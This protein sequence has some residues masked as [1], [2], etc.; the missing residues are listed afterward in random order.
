VSVGFEGAVLA[1][2]ASRRMGTDKAFVAAPDGRA[3]VAVA[4]EALRDA[5]AARTFVVGGDRAGIESLGLAWVAD[6]H[7]GEGP[8]GG[9]VT[10]LLASEHD[11]VVVLAC[12]MPEVD[13]TVPEAL[14]RGLRDEPAAGVAVALAGRRE[15]PLTSCWRR[16]VALPVLD[17][18]F[19]SG[20]RAPRHLLD[21]LAV[22]RVAG[23]PVDRLADVDSPD[24]LRRYADRSLRPHTSTRQDLP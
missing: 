14:V 3:L 19:A 6:R 24:D 1:G 16:S 7:P 5:G 8:L 2:G 15:Q 10:A 13:A 4:A 23:L 9:I 17:E 18:A 11:L 12:D 20:E 22:I 21:R